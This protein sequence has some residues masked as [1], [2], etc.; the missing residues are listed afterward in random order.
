MSGGA[1]AKAQATSRAS[2]VKGSRRF[3]YAPLSSGLDL[4]CIGQHE[5]ATV[6]VT[7]VDQDTG[8]NRLTP[9]SSTLRRIGIVGLAGL[10]GQRDGA[11]PRLG[12]ALTY[13]RRYALFTLVGIAGQIACFVWSDCLPPLKV[14]RDESV[15]PASPNRSSPS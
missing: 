8:L 12:A 15:L 14:R 1:L 7:A 13:A 4:L 3:R 9:P 11:P 2:R 6:Q 5:I 10:P